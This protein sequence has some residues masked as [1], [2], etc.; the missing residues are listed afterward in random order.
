MMRQI[1]Q[2]IILGAGAPMQNDL[3]R[4][5]VPN[6]EIMKYEIPMPLKQVTGNQ[7][8]GELKICSCSE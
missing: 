8:R 2:V 3:F 4:I 6:D 7:Y 5:F 1:E